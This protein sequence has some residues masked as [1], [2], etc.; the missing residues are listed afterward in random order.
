MREIRMEKW[1]QFTFSSLARFNSIMIRPRR[2]R[3]HLEWR[4][5]GKV[6]NDRV[7][8]WRRFHKELCIIH[9]VIW[10]RNQA[11]STFP[12]IHH[13]I[14]IVRRDCFSFFHFKT[15][16]FFLLES[17]WCSRQSI[18]FVF[19]LNGLWVAPSFR[20]CW[21]HN[22]FN[23]KLFLRFAFF[24]VSDTGSSTESTNRSISSIIYSMYHTIGFNGFC[25]FFSLSIESQTKKRRNKASHI[26]Q[27]KNYWI[28][29]F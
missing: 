16:S 6:N 25:Y 10:L 4:Q 28:F 20:E 22:E 15:R 14:L 2:R 23:Q 21:M 18:L 26:S 5:Q 11:N 7:S 1:E 9:H 8:V 29:F 12:F 24:I 19:P 3:T 27:K 13:C 17:F